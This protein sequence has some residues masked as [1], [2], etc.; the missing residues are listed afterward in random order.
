[1]GHA[2]DEGFFWEDNVIVA[3]DFSIVAEGI[4]GG[5]VDA[6]SRSSWLGKR[7]S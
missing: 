7:T 2:E 1:V 3:K 4:G 5:G 6:A